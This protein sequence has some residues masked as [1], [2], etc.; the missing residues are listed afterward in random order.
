MKTRHHHARSFM[1]SKLVMTLFVVLAAGLYAASFLAACVRRYVR[2]G[3]TMLDRRTP[4]RVTAG[5]PSRRIRSGSVRHDPRVAMRETD[6]DEIVAA[7]RDLRE[8]ACPAR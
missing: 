7:L 1:D 5:A 4:V 6:V 2:L 8:Q 3:R